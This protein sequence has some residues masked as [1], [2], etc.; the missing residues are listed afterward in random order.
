MFIQIIEGISA[1]VLVTCAIFAIS[2]AVFYGPYYFIW[3]C[4]YLLKLLANTYN[5]MDKLPMSSN[6]YNTYVFYWYVGIVAL[7]AFLIFNICDTIDLNKND[8]KKN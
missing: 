4:N 2:G 3:S 6:I 7:I 8:K 5:N 1:I